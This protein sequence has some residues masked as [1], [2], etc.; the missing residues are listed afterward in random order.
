MKN[1]II[2]VGVIGV[3]SMGQQH[4]R[5]YS[6]LNRVKLV[7]VT[8]I[9]EEHGRLTSKKYGGLFFKDYREM[10]DKAKVE[11]V[12]IAVP[13]SLHK[14]VALECIRRQ[15]PVLIEKPIADSLA[16]AEEIIREAK[17][18]GVKVA[19]GHVER[20]NPVIQELKAVIRQQKLSRLISIWA[21]RVG[22]F[23]PRVKDANVIVDLAVHD[24]DICNFLLGKT[25]NMV[26]ARA[27]KALNSKRVDYASI[28]IQ[29][30]DVNVM[31]QVN[32]ITP[33]KI[34]ELCVTGTKG[35]V[36]LNYLTQA[37]KL[38]ESNYEQGYDSTGDPVVKFGSTRT[39]E[40]NMRVEEPLKLEL[41]HFIGCVR[42]DKPPVVSAQDGLAALVVALKAV[43]S[44]EHNKI[45]E[46]HCDG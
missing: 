6:E 37:L 43:E 4:A 33:V 13:S 46:V 28:F 2:S 24:I 40:I 1:D 11:A 29:Y 14:E 17:R 32:W 20:F 18:N 19:V 7:A 36:E 9:N 27:G 8:D 42:D 31:I 44:S 5:V 10:L 12:S 34:R 21:K 45:M 15:I 41:S 23:P 30:D 25:P 3:G 26:Y 22:V 16:S 38:Y 39:Q 35:Y